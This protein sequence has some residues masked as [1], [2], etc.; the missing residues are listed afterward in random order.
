M[1]MTTKAPDEVRAAFEEFAKYLDMLASDQIASKR[2][3]STQRGKTKCDTT[4]STYSD[5]ATALREME[6]KQEEM[7]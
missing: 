1:I 4:A 2:W 6:F 7:K 5:I 3:Q